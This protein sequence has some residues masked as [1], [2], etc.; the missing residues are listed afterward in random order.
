MN[1]C[2]KLRIL[3]K[4]YRIE[5]VDAETLESLGVDGACLT[6]KGRIMISDGLSDEELRETKIHEVLHAI[7]SGMDIGY[8]D[9]TEE[10][11]V[12]ALAKGLSALITD[13]NR[14]AVEDLIQL[15]DVPA[16][17]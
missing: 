4:T 9:A 3:G 10:K 14:A 5:R 13:N 17:L 7:W 11:V 15:D 16:P 12:T 6:S 2:D 8:S 1:S